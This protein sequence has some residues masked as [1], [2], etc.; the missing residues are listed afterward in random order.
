MEVCELRSMGFRQRVQ[1][2]FVLADAS[3]NFFLCGMAEINS[4][5]AYAEI[6]AILH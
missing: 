3:Q 6:C 2:V 1:Q 4:G 5:K